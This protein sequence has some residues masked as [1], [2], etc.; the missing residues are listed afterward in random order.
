MIALVVPRP[1]STRN[2]LSENMKRM[3]RAGISGH[4]AISAR[5]AW[6]KW[7]ANIDRSQPFHRVLTLDLLNTAAWDAARNNDRP[8][9]PAYPVEKDRRLFFS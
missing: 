2:H 3:L 9:W 1:T 7:R 8:E 6:T 5:W 4:Y